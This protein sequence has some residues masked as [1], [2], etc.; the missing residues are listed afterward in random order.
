MN[1]RTGIIACIGVFIIIMIMLFRRSCSIRRNEMISETN[2]IDENGNIIGTSDDEEN[3]D[4]DLG[5]VD[6]NDSEEVGSLDSSYDE[7]MKFN[8]DFIQ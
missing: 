6:Y 4:E 7:N 8:W 3:N 2:K 5:Q 1:K